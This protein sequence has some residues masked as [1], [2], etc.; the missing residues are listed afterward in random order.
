MEDILF[1]GRTEYN[2]TDEMLKEAIQ[3]IRDKM[4]ARPAWNFE[5][6]FKNYNVDE[7]L[8]NLIKLLIGGRNPQTS[9]LE[10]I[11][12]S[13]VLLFQIIEQMILTDRQV[14]L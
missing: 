11:T 7:S 10:M 9:K 5:G 8:L 6:N 14:N 3:L 13:A 4:L 1:K 12:K 2:N